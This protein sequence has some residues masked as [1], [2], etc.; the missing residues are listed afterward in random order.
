MLYIFQAQ[1]ETS[2]LFLLISVEEDKKE[3]KTREEMRLISTRMY[4][5]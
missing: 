4:A 5:P 3:E 1:D 2:V